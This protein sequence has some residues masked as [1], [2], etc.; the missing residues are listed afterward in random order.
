MPELPD[1]SVYIERLDAL[2]RGQVLEGTRV[3]S[4]FLVRTFEPPLS[5]THGKRVTGFRRIGKRIVFELE[6]DLFLV[7]HLMIAGRFHL[8]E[9]GDKLAG[10]APL[11]GLDFPEHTLVL[12]EQGTKR[13]ASLFVVR[14][15]AGLAEFSRGGLE[16]LGSKLAD[17]KAAL[18]LENRTVK[19]AL[20]DPRLFSGIGNAYSDEILHAA[21]LSPVKL[22]RSMSDA[23]IARLHA[24]TERVLTW[25]IEHLSAEVGSGFPEKVTAF[26][27]EMA[28]HGKF[29]KPCPVC[30]TPVQR[31]AF[32]NNE[33][34][35]CPTCQTGGKL[36]ADRGLSRLLK[37]DWP[38]TLEELEE[39]KAARREA[40]LAA[41]PKSETEP[42]PTPSA[43]AQ[44]MTTQQVR[45]INT[46]RA[47]PVKRA[48]PDKLSGKE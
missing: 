30:G 16:V 37:T 35:Y 19:R 44:K 3:R 18:V 28:V 29:Q 47:K 43:S 36:L 33:L 12:T 1:V 23:E 5:A 15:E 39:F 6:D 34:D 26:R 20:T 25:W 40:P 7:F 11:I 8:K 48:A 42:A 9:K 31:V 22:T 46:K 27:A 2:F 45:P 17:F 10:K 4:P 14:G 24:E 13:R 38:K 41:E 32:A 21:K